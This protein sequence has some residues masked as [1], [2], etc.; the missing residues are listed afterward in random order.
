MNQ[1]NISLDE[2]V[3]TLQSFRDLWGT[4]VRNLSRLIN[5]KTIQADD[6]RSFL[7]IKRALIHRYQALQEAGEMDGSP[8]GFAKRM[9][10]LAGF[11][12]IS[13]LSDDQLKSLKEIVQTVDQQ[14]D[15]WFENVKREDNFLDQVEKDKRRH[16]WRVFFMIPVFFG[17]LVLLF[18]VFGV[19]FFLNR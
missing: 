10:L 1:A 13:S 8:D 5:Q 16:S 17:T 14:L 12:R 3:Q 4:F 9:D 15:E 2:T 7:E 19:R 6:E 18:V 11:N